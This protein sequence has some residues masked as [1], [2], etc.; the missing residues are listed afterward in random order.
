MLKLL[1]V[2]IGLIST[3]IMYVIQS[4]GEIVTLAIGVVSIAFGPLLGIFT[5]GLFFPTA[6]SKVTWMF[7]LFISSF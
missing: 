3:V 1:V 7:Y 4:L 5:L 6:N 2:I